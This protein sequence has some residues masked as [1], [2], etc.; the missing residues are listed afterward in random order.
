MGHYDRLQDRVARNREATDLTRV[1]ATA[2]EGL[3]F[4]MEV[5]T[6][7][8]SKG[9]S[10]HPTEIRSETREAASFAPPPEES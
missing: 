6:R 10:R 3:I 7:L 8:V 1:L 4:A 5:Q 9:T 2:G